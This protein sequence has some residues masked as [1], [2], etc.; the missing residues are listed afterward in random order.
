M[1][2][3]PQLDRL[4][5][6]ARKPEFLFIE[7]VKRVISDGTRTLELLNIGPNPHA[8]DMV[9]A[10]LPKERVVFQGDL[11]FLPANDAP[12]GPPQAS[13]VSFAKKLQELKLG[14]DRIASV[15]GRTTTIEELNRA[16]QSAAPST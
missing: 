10:Y 1:A 2:A 16:M 8:R 9:V 4:A 7:R 5:K 3:A 11:F 14:V 6:S 13:T 15:H 12:V